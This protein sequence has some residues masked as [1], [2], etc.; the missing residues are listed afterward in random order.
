MK[1]KS[2]LFVQLSRGLL[3]AV[4]LVGLAATPAEAQVANDLESLVTGGKVKLDVRY[5]YE[6]VNDDLAPL[7]AHASTVRTR[8]GF[9]T[10]DLRGLQGYVEMENTSA[11][12]TNRYNVPGASPHGPKKPGRAIVADPEFTELNQV[13]AQFTGPNNTVLRGGRQRVKLDNDRFIGNVGWRQNE[14][15]YDAIT[16]NT[17]ILPQTHIF[18]GYF[19]NANTI[20]GT[21]R[22]MNSHIVNLHYSGLP[23]SQLAAYAYL[24][25]FDPGAGTD[26]RTLG[27]RFSGAM[28]VGDG[29]KLIYWAEYA[30]QGDYKDAAN[31]NADY[32]R[33][34]LGGSYQGVT[35]KGGYEL[36]G[37]DGGTAAFQT[38]LATLHAFNGW[39][40]RFLATPASGLEDISATVATKISKVKLLL[41]YHNFNADKGGTNFGQE[42]D[43]QATAKIH[44][45]VVVGVKFAA[46]DANNPGA[47][48]ANNDVQ[49]V[50]TWLG[51]KF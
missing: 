37:S 22:N 39:A 35:V 47:G 34:E 30:N 26:S 51:L 14:Q 2:F 1:I 46:Y 10:G 12:F 45:W 18:Y 48:P 15:T 29:F 24:L 40:D 16:L 4:L 6:F 28:P 50:W 44:K 49:K 21:D 19:F 31:F 25:D 36:L 41:V 27:V 3:G 17:D 42:F 38:P 5:R 20:I 43:V 7:N 33:F 32:L 23:H 11:I 13:W 9:L 8:L